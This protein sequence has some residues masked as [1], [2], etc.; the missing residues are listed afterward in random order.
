MADPVT[1]IRATVDVVDASNSLITSLIAF[2]ATT[3]Y[4]ITAAAAFLPKPKN[5]APGYAK[6]IYAVI[7]CVAWN[8]KHARNID[9]DRRAADRTPENKDTEQ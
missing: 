6:K 8:I 2:V 4:A 3:G 1:T 5:N 7:T 9:D